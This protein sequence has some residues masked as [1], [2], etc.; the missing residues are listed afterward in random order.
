VTSW[1]SACEIFPQ[2]E[3]RSPLLARYEVQLPDSRTVRLQARK[4][5]ARR[6]AEAVVELLEAAH[7][8]LVNAPPAP[9]RSR[10]D[11]SVSAA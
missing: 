7:R 8:H 3:A 2:P 5:A 10:G 6:T 11:G 1:V 9:R 4:R